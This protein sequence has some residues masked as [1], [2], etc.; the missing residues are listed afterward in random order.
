M[1]LDDHAIKDG[2]SVTKD[3]RPLRVLPEGVTFRDSPTHADDRGTVC[4]IFDPRWGWHADPLVFVYYFTIRPGMIK[5]WGMH[6]KHEDRYFIL[7]GEMEVVFYD[8]RPG[9]PTRGQVSSVVMS[10]A[11]R[12]LMNI[13]AGVWHANH[14]IGQSDLIVVNCPTLPF[15]HGDPDKYRLPLDTPEI[16]YSFRRT[17]GW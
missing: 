1:P 9:S 16:P 17:R 15:D 13:P 10:E 11:R 12:Q 14:N 8:A 7:K 2:A 3:G 6:K 5:G 4:E